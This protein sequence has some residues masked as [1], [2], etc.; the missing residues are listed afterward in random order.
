MFKDYQKINK[1]KVILYISKIN[2]NFDYKTFVKKHNLDLKTLKKY[3]INSNQKFVSF[4]LKKMI[5]NNFVK[6][7]EN[8]NF[9]IKFNEFGK[10]FFENS[11]IHFNISHSHNYVIA[12]V[13]NEQIGID[14]EKEKIV[15][16]GISKFLL[17]PNDDEFYKTNLLECWN[18][19]EAFSKLLG[20]GMTTFFS[21]F[22]IKN[23]TIQYLD[24]H[25]FFLKMILDQNKKICIA[26]YQEIDK[27]NIKIIEIDN[28]YQDFF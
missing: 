10:P 6:N 9:E 15:K 22:L 21:N 18:V 27:K 12:A 23:N 20:I 7:E 5:W 14:I 17:N 28:N 3:K 2:K 1:E 16:L 19:K 24:N 11:R 13:S 26:S 25:A 4:V 8:Q